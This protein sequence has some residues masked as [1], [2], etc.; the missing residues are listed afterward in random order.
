MNWSADVDRATCQCVVGQAHSN[1]DYKTVLHEFGHVFGFDD[2]YVEPGPACQDGQENSVM[3][4]ASFDTLQPD[5]CQRD[6]RALLHAER[7]LLQAP[8]GLWRVVPK[9]V[10][11]NTRLYVGDVNRDGRSDLDLQ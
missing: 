10:F 7:E 1:D 6:S 9:W 11:G 4:S 8:Q 3:C 5:R 2:T